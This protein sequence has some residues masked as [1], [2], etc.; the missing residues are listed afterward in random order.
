MMDGSQVVAAGFSSTERGGHAAQGKEPEEEEA[1][2][3]VGNY[4]RN[5]EGEKTGRSVSPKN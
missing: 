5:D 4:L 1:R 3:W 2:R